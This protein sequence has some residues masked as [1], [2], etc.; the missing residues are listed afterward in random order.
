M[1]EFIFGNRILVQIVGLLAA[2]TVHEFAHAWMA[3]RLGDPTARLAGRLTLNPIAHIDLYGTVL[4]PGFL[5]L[6]GSPF[7]IGWA[8]PVMFDPFN[9][10]N[11]KR[12]SALI[13]LAG[14]AA[15]L[16]VATTLSIAI[17]LLITPFSPLNFLADLLVYLIVIN[18][19]LAIFNLI[20]IHPLDGGKILVGILPDKDAREVDLFLRK[21]G[22]LLLLFMLFPIA[23]GRSPIF[24]VI[25]PVISF[26]L[27]LLVPGLVV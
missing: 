3:N 7:V 25:G 1:L 26:I 10:E 23:G 16:I 8:K 21:W 18:V 24:M 17:R 6:I 4:I 2:I 15:N 19:V 22:M 9:L 27:G 13:S 11:P 5:L 12:D 20:P 14:P